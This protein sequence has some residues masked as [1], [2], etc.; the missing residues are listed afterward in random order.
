MDDDSLYCY[1]Y[2][3]HY[4]EYFFCSSARKEKLLSLYFLFHFFLCAGP[5]FSIWVL[6][7]VQ[8][9]QQQTLIV[10]AMCTHR[11]HTRMNADNDFVCFRSTILA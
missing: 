9:R 4:Y 6:V 7:L 3:Y 11:A 1:Y 8:W 2:Y 10:G 5:H